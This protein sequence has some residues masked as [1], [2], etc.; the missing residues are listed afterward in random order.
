MNFYPG[1]QHANYQS[2]TE[3]ELIKSKIPSL[4]ELTRE[5]LEDQITEAD[6]NF[7]NCATYKKFMEGQ[8][9]DLRN[10]RIKEMNEEIERKFG[11]EKRQIDQDHSNLIMLSNA[12]VDQ[13][14]SLK[15]P[16]L[17]VGTPLVTWIKVWESTGVGM[18]KFSK[19]IKVREATP[20]H[21]RQ[22]CFYSNYRTKDKSIPEGGVIEQWSRD[23]VRKKQS[24]T[25]GLPEVGD[26]IVRHFLKSGKTGTS[27]HIY[28]GPKQEYLNCLWLEVGEDPNNRRGIR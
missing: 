11:R 1:P 24:G 17:P 6:K 23:A 25:W 20:S 9:N 12:I 7:K 18:D 10:A 5:Q 19:W 4:C 27:F 21:H 13:F 22:V 28:K 16:I 14:N 2:Y 3:E 8:I 15:P 26:T